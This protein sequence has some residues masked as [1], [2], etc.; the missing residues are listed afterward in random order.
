MLMS[1]ATNYSPTQMTNEK[2]KEMIDEV[3]KN[4]RHAYADCLV[5]SGTICEEDGKLFFNPSDIIVKNALEN[6]GV[7]VHGYEVNYFKWWD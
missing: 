5:P 1:M 2:L 3:K 7:I 4:Q 6:V